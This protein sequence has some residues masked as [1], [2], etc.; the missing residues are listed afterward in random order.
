MK[1]SLNHIISEI[2]RKENVISLSA[3]NA[4]NEAYQMTIYLKSISTMV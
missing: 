1:S 3:P 2:Q 4:I